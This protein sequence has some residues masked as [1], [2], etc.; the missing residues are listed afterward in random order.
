MKFTLALLVPLALTASASPAVLSKRSIDCNNGVYL[1]CNGSGGQSGS[2]NTVVSHCNGQTFTTQSKILRLS[3]RSSS[4]L[5]DKA[6]MAQPGG[7]GTDLRQCLPITLAT[8]DRTLVLRTLALAP[9]KDLAAVREAQVAQVAD[10]RM[11]T[12]VNTFISFVR[13]KRGVCWTL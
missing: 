11:L 10:T 1:C 4:R 7:V 9:T 13:Q 6:N 12:F 3:C 2:G 5:Q 8:P